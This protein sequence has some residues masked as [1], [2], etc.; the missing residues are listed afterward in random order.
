M[1]EHREEREA[2]G[3]QLM[4]EVF[5]RSMGDP[6][7]PSRWWKGLGLVLV[8]L[9]GGVGLLLAIG[10]RTPE[11]PEA[12]RPLV[13]TSRGPASPL[14]AQGLQA[15]TH[16]RVPAAVSPEGPLLPETPA[17]GS[18]PAVIPPAVNAQTGRGPKGVSASLTASP[19]SKAS[20]ARPSLMHKPV[21]RQP[22]IPRSPRSLLEEFDP[23]AELVRSQD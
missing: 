13:A 17:E 7:P 8:V 10:T 4:M 6:P 19:R 11:T 23:N 5:T 12:R 3:Y 9:G 21:A 15:G 14:P 1:E 20:R 16:P 18:R 2:A 22:S